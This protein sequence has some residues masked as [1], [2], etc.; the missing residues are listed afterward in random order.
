VILLLVIA[1]DVVVPLGIVILVGGEVELLPL[2][3]VSDE[4]C[5][6]AA[7]EVAPR[8]SPPLLAEHVQNSEFSRQQGDLIIGNALVLLIRSCTQERQ[9]KL[10][11]R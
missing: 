3:A 2:G 6:V 8:R 7:L 9:S 10:Q 11:S 1:L 5:G 4:V